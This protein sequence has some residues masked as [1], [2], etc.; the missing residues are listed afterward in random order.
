MFGETIYP[1]DELFTTTCR[2]RLMLV[3]EEP[4]PYGPEMCASPAQAAPL[5]H[6]LVAGLDR[7]V[8][9]A[10]FLDTRHRAVGH[11][12]AYIGTLNRTV[13]E[14]RGILVPA[15]LSNAAGVIVF[16]NH[17]SGDPSPSPEDLAFTRKLAEA[18]DAVGVRLVDHLILGDPPTF[19][20]LKERGHW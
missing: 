16:H 5:L 9:G 20:S 12:V 18:S 1:I 13:A 14:P 8:L 15:L 3:R 10:L 2:F 6:R 19:V 11:T 7:E 4:E 17:P